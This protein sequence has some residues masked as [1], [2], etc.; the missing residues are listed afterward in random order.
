M[1]S[2]YTLALSAVFPGVGSVAVAK[3]FNA[4]FAFLNSVLSVFKPNCLANKSC[5]ACLK[6]GV[7]IAGL[8][9]SVLTFS[10]SAKYADFVS[11]VFPSVSADSV[12]FNLS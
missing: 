6:L 3:V 11:F 9:N 4:S 10:N 7:L 8:T 1:A 12:A 5:K 2:L